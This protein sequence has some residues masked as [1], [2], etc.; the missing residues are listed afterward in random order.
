MNN[1]MEWTLK[2]LEEERR[3]IIEENNEI[4]INKFLINN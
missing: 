2:C 4:N 1:L 3:Q